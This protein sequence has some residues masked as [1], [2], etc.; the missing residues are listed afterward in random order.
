MMM[1]RNPIYER[2]RW[3]AA[4]NR[5]FAVLVTAFA[6]LLSAVAFVSMLFLFHQAAGTGE[7]QYQSFL[8]IF[9]TLAWV[10]FA[11][12][13]TLVPARTAAGIS[14][15]R[16]RKTM[17]LILTTPITPADLSA[18]VL[19]AAL[20]NAAVILFCCMPPF[21]AVLLFG[22][23]RMTDLVLL[24]AGC[25]AAAFFVGSLG[26]FFSAFSARTSTAVA[27]TYA[28]EA[29]LFFGPFL[30]LFLS[31][32]IRSAGNLSCFW[33]LI[34]PVGIFYTGLSAAAGSGSMPLDKILNYSVPEL[35][36]LFVCGIL[37]ECA[38][39]LLL[40]YFASWETARGTVGLRRKTRKK[41]G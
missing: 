20:A 39:A 13:C 25:M 17:D 16:E 12:I 35:R 36:R 40:T 7:L 28:V 38:A 11:G 19:S 29:L 33:T 24:M 30:I 2:E 27:V 26:L 8:E 10:E 37:C 32:D 15:E 1:T 6:A 34:S 3:I 5:R 41:R 31:N 4:G 22:G 21:A 23:V 14:G 9:R 18:G